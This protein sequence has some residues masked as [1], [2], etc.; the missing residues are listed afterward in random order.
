MEILTESNL[1]CLDNYENQLTIFP[2]DL[3]NKIYIGIEQ[4]DGITW[5]IKQRKKGH[6][7]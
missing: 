3:W 5:F 7:N 4:N 6:T 2:S 1:L